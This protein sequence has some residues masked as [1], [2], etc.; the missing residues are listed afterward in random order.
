M[1]YMVFAFDN[2]YPKGG[3]NDL[4]ASFTDLNDLATKKPIPSDYLIY[5]I[6]NTESGRLRET[7][8]RDLFDDL[9]WDE[10]VKARAT[11]IENFIKTFIEGDK[12]HGEATTR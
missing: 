2:Y 5:Q 1:A 6:L 7:S 12:H 8:T 3:M 11:Y 4:K 10:E 9:G